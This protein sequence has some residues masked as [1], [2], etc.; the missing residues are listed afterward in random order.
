MT[1]TIGFTGDGDSNR[2]ID[3]AR[4]NATNTTVLQSSQELREFWFQVS[5]SSSNSVADTL[6]IALYEMNADG[7][8]EGAPKAFEKVINIPAFG[9]S[10]VDPGDQTTVDG[11]RWFRIGGFN[12]SL[13]AHAGKE[14]A[15]VV[16]Y[17]NG[18]V[19]PIKGATVTSA[20]R[21]GVSDGSGTP[22]ATW[23]GYS[24][25]TAYGAYVVTETTLAISSV[26]ADN[27][28][29]DGQAGISVAGTALDTVTTA[30]FQ[31]TDAAYKSTVTASYLASSSTAATV[32]HVRGNLPFTTASYALELWL[33]D[34]AN[35]DTQTVT[36]NP[37]SGKAV[38]EAAGTLVITGDS[39]AVTP[40]TGP[41]PVVGDQLLYDSTSAQSG[42]V[43][44]NPD[45]TFTIDYGTAATPATDSFG[46]ELWSSDGTK[47][48]WTAYTVTVTEPDTA[49]DA[50]TFT[51]VIDQQINTFVASAPIAVTG[52]DDGYDIPISVTGGQY[53]VSIDGGTTWGAWTSADGVVQ[54]N[55]QVK[56]GHTTPATYNTITDTQVTIG[57]QF[58]TFSTTTEAPADAT[59]DA[60]A[61]ADLTGQTI[62]TL[63]ESNDVTVRGVDADTGIAVSVTGGEYAVSTDSGAT[64]GAWTTT[65]TNVELGYQLKVRHRTSVNYE[66]VTSTTLTI[67]GVSDTFS[68]TTAPP[69]DTT[70]D[71]FSFTDQTDVALST[72]VESAPVTISGIAADTDVAVS[73]TGGDYAVSSDS[74]ATWG[75]YTATAGS[76]R[77][78]DQVKVRHTSSASLSTATDTVLTVGGISDTFTSTTEAP[79]RPTIL[80][81]MPNVE[82]D[83]GISFTRALDDYIASAD[84]FDVDGFPAG[85][86]FS[87]DL[88]TRSITGAANNSD[89][90]ASPYTVSVTASSG[91][92]YRG[93][94]FQVMIYNAYLNLR[95]KADKA[96]LDVEGNPVEAV[97]D[98]WAL[99]ETDPRKKTTATVVNVLDSGVSYD[100]T[101]GA[102]TLVDLIPDTAW[103][104]AWNDSGSLNLMVRAANLELTR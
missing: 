67:G 68:T 45:L 66:T 30:L 11:N 81:L 72:V 55:D 36:I 3:H 100:L 53:A 69:P 38:V 6:Y 46:V 73:I 27:I 37:P 21:N 57:N 14:L 96:P 4:F 9:D 32:D 50:F 40:Y 51:D 61:F 75:A 76:V 94:S 35:F 90:Q 58:D 49:P 10:T 26:D 65:G 31:T 104:H 52:V 33:D 89:V 16:G 91:G 25:T 93:D 98:N 62:D 2:T 13:K 86:G 7:T 56:A 48:V 17:P 47:R 43:T 22:P 60:F 99:Y 70:P 29:T 87:Y 95:I 41:D 84:A 44:V 1:Q 97:L 59:P 74:G 88:A 103:L 78:N 102:D 28:V 77:L 64:W 39:S 20:P 101:K 24:D 83:E 79:P 71:A 8:T 18:D 19:I 34:G 42:T 63:V 92:G 23:S 80:K 85:S 5:S 82:L 15:L 12:D 54:L